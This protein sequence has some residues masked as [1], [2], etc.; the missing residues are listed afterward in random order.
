MKS[1]GEYFSSLL[2]MNMF[3]KTESSKDPLD[4]TKHDKEEVQETKSENV[5]ETKSENGEETKSENSEEKKETEE[6][7]KNETFE[8]IEVAE[9]TF[10][11]Q[12]KDMFITKF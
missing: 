3:L 11:E 2:N 10:D 6:E 12:T 4:K 9:S 1:F 8:F 7:K 5:E